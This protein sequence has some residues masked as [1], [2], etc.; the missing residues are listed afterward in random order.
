MAVEKKIS[1]LTA[2]TTEIQPLDLLEV[3]EWNG[4]TYD[5]KSVSGENLILHKKVTLTAAQIKTISS[6]PVSVISA[7][8]AGKVIEIVSAFLRFNYGTVTFDASFSFEVS[9]Y[10]DTAGGR[11]YTTANNILNRTSSTI[12]TFDK[13][14]SV[15]DQLIS[16]KAIYID[17]GDDSTVGDSTIDLYINYRII[18]L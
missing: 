12:Q 17:G 15:A 5:T 6:V 13:N 10:A 7:P 11:Q 9:L 14:T 1:E 3:S 18:T 2:K 4:A 8:G 16:N